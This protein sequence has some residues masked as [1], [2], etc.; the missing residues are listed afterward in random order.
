MLKFDLQA[1]PQETAAEGWIRLS[2][3]IRYCAGDANEKLKQ[4]GSERAKQN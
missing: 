1:L 2:P 3:A 4:K